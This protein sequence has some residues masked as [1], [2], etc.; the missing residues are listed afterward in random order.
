[1]LSL[2]LEPVGPSPEDDEDGDELGSRI[3][4]LKFYMFGRGHKNH[5]AC[6]AISEASGEEADE[7]GAR[8]G[9]EDD[10]TRCCNS[11]SKRSAH[12]TSGAPSRAVGGDEGAEGEEEAFSCGSSDGRKRSRADR[13]GSSPKAFSCGSSDEGEDGGAPPSFF[14]DELQGF[15]QSGIYYFPLYPGHVSLLEL[16]ATS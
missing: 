9:G 5:P 3:P 1:M 6:W 7:D 10:P 11:T 12:S 16:F 2:S 4:V 14:G 13:R 8:S 15:V